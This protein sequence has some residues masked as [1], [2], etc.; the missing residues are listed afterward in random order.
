MAV[1][2]KFAVLALVGVLAGCASS[3]SSPDVPTSR[4]AVT[5]SARA[6]LGSAASS[7]LPSPV[8]SLVDQAKFQ[9][10][11]KNI[12]CDLAPGAVRCEIV[13][14]D[15]EPPPRPAA[16]RLGWGHGMSIEN[17]KPD[18]VCAGDT[19]NGTATTVLPYGSSLR[20]GSIQCDSGDAAMRC[21]DQKSEHGFTL[22]VQDYNLF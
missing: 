22:S 9:S 6:G 3:G 1:N 4:A 11:S 17:G 21:V 10:P 16:C 19:I 18:F 14:R 20:A 5:P 7:S 15:W 12:T 8:V 2:P 13:K